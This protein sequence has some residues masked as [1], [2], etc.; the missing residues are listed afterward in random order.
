MTRKCI[1][2]E[3]LLALME[4]QRDSVLEQPKSQE[5]CS[6]L[7]LPTHRAV[8]KG[9]GMAFSRI[10]PIFIPLMLQKDTKNDAEVTFWLPKLLSF[11]RDFGSCPSGCQSMSHE[12]QTDHHHT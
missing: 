2:N 10:S 5:L 3:F 4:L 1:S 11:Q 12:G 9:P 7:V 8:H 6:S